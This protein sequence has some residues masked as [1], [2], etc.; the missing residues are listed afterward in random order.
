MMTFGPISI[1]P[2]LQRRGLRLSQLPRGVDVQ[3]LDE[4]RR[5]DHPRYGALDQVRLRLEEDGRW[6]LVRLE[7]AAYRPDGEDQGGETADQLEQQGKV[8]KTGKGTYRLTL[9]PQ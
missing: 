5:A 3:L 6:L 8:V 4:L 2:D 9:E 7:P 1:R